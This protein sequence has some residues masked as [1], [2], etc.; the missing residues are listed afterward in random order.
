M[1]NFARLFS[2]PRRVADLS[3][4][5]L[6]LAAAILSLVFGKTGGYYLGCAVL[7]SAIAG[8]S[9][10]CL[11]SGRRYSNWMVPVMFAGLAV[12][13]LS[14]NKSAFGGVVFAVLAALMARGNIVALRY[15]RRP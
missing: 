14:F 5:A 10:F 3:T 7:M 12:L 6:F 13:M 4:A 1:K 2:L 15:S 8:Y 11:F 9:V